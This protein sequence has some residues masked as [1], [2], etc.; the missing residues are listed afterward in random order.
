MGSITITKPI[1]EN[2]GSYGRVDCDGAFGSSYNNTGNDATTGETITAQSVGLSLILGVDYP[3]EAA[4]YGFQALGLAN[5]PA[6]S[7][8]IKVFQGGSG[9]TGATS[10]GTPAGTNGT[11]AV[12]GTGA[13]S[14][15]VAIT[16]G[17]F[18]VVDDATPGGNALYMNA[19]TQF[20]YF[21][22]NMA[23]ATA[24]QVLV[25]TGAAMQV[26]YSATPAT[27]AVQVYFKKANTN[28]QRMV[29][30]MTALGAPTFI[31]V[32]C[33]SGHNIR[34]YHDAAAAGGAAITVDDTAQIFLTGNLVGGDVANTTIGGW[35]QDTTDGAAVVTVSS[36][37]G[38]AA[39]QV[40][41]GS[42]LATHTHTIG[43]TGGGE[44]PN[45]TDLSVSL[46]SVR[47]TIYG[48]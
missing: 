26:R 48:K 11:S 13:G 23:T 43:A 36:L 38:T 24:N 14:A 29:A 10:G 45:G 37:S 47:F 33:F 42:A 15:A 30:D 32:P 28:G 46:A 3:S 9:T 20:A 17:S 5:G 18:N 22:S 31:Q 1:Y 16:A 6:S 4:G 34:V 8:R 7:V 27:D 40:F 2:D 19:N 39:A 44:V 41:T 21:V 12:T 35:S 25:G